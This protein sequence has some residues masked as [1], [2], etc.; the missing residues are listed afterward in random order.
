MRNTPP[1]DFDVWIFEQTGLWLFG[2]ATAPEP[3]RRHRSVADLI[4]IG[5][6]APDEVRQGKA[7]VA[8]VYLA[9]ANNRPIDVGRTN[10]FPRRFAE[11]AGVHP[12]EWAW[13]WFAGVLSIGVWIHPEANVDARR[14]K[15]EMVYNHLT[16][17]GLRLASRQP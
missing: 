6:Y 4:F 14:W 2:P 9:E 5:P 3:P 11:N 7:G 16:G 10:F 8:G 13:A 1:S 17:L 12:R 15:E